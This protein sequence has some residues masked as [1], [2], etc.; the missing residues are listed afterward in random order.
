LVDVSL[1]GLA[2]W[3]LSPD[4][5]VSQIHGGTAIPKFGH[6][7]SPNPLVSTYRTKD[8]RYVQLMMLQL[9]KFYPEAMRVIGLPELVD[10]P[11]FADPA[12]RYENRVALIALLDEAFAKRTVAEWRETLA[13]LSGAWGIVQTPAELCE[14]P[15]VTAN[16]YVAHTETVNGVPFAI[17]TNPVQFDEKSVTPPGAPEHGQHT[18]EILMD[19]GIGWDTIEELKASGA[20]L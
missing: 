7:D 14:D 17:P 15:A 5:A 18:E 13:A 9:D 6:A 19:A 2:A 8:G 4:V 12:S 3:N 10:D 1:L 16:G 20:I 11:R